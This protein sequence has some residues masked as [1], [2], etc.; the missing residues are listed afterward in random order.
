M[1]AR[2]CSSPA[3]ACLFGCEGVLAHDGPAASL[4]SLIVPT[5]YARAY[6]CAT[7]RRPPGVSGTVFNETDG[8]EVLAPFAAGR[9]ELLHPANVSRATATTLASRRETAVTGS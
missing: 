4:M 2:S 9:L 5:R 3:S 6:A 8:S 1:P 7:S